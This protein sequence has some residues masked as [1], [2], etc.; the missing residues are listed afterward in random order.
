MTTTLPV[1]TDGSSTPSPATRAARS[2]VGGYAVVAYLA[3]LTSMLY[4]AGFLVDLVVGKDIDSPTAA[5]ASH[6]TARAVAQDVAL[7]LLF[8]AT[9]SIMARRW[10]K[11]LLT[12]VV[13]PAME[14][15]TFVLVA[16]TTLFVLMRWWTPIPG[17]FWHATGWVRIAILLLYAAGWAFAL[18][19]TF[20]VSHPD[21]FGLRQ[22]WF[23]L[24]GR[25]YVPP[26]LDRDGLHRH[27]RHPLMAGLLIVVWATPTMT[28][29]HLVLTVAMTGYV[30]AGIAFEERDLL[31]AYGSAYRAYRRSTPMLIPRPGRHR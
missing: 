12:R 31:R 22:A 29:S 20:E 8:G 6:G 4:F 27:I 9:H 26:A 18:V 28:A 30:M 10:F 7:V 21:L 2:L 25:P 13:P 24:R 23:A 3:A 15:S 19:S 11:R 14:R 16:S 5:S 1:R 17:T